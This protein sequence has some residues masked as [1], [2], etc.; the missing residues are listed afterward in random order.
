MRSIDALYR[1]KITELLLCANGPSMAFDRERVKGGERSSP[2]PQDYGSRVYEF[3]RRWRNAPN[4]QIRLR[5]ISEI[6][7]ELRRMK[8]SR[9][10]KGEYGTLELKVAVARD[11]RSE[12][13]VSYAYGLSVKTV[14]QYRQEVRDRIIAA[15]DKGDKSLRDVAR[16]F[17]IS[18]SFVAKFA[19]VP[20]DPSAIL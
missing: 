7:D 19:G 1:G 20:S 14:R 10:A 5:I 2:L 16:D 9:V 12:D 3:H 11:R 4:D 15:L 8:V 13:V 6:V 18:H 17:G